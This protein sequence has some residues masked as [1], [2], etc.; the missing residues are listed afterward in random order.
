MLLDPDT[1]ERVVPD[2]VDPD[3]STGQAALELHL[4]RYRF[5]AR[6]ARPGRL[7]DIACGVGYGTRLVADEAPVKV[8]ALG[9]DISP[10]AI[11]YARTRYGRPGVDFRVADALEFEDHERFDTVVTLETIEHLPEPSKFVARL[12]G[13]LRPGGVLLAS[14]PVTPSVDVNPH[15]RSD[16]T[17]RSFRRLFTERGLTEQTSFRQVQQVP[18]LAVL[19][20]NERRLADVKRSLPA[21]Y[22][23]H[24]DA[25]LRRIWATVRHGFTNRYVTIAWKRP[26]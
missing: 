15:H 6:E 18:I 24:P 2:I 25:A 11:S 4:E 14:V 21:Y 16:F 13:M 19:R 20:G 3:D 22:V 8:A 7:L 23:R 9:V 10:E 5:A 1:L 12:I 17:E 26:G